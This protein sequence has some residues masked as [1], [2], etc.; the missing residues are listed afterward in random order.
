MKIYNAAIATLILLLGKTSAATTTK[1]H[2]SLREDQDSATR[3]N[4][5]DRINIRFDKITYVDGIP[6][7]GDNPRPM[8][9][10]DYPITLPTADFLRQT[11]AVSVIQQDDC[12][13]CDI[14]TRDLIRA[15]GGLPTH[16]PRTP[17]RSDPYWD[18]LYEV[19]EVQQG[20]L[21]DADPTLYMP[22]PKIWEDFDIH[23]VAEAVHDEVRNSAVD[24]KIWNT[25]RS[26]S[27]TYALLPFSV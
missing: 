2:T 20:R 19:I 8:T 22:L 14:P 25:P 21:D 4:L 17:N 26:D 27:L 7:P 5:Q 18:D 24:M 13:E 15:I 3:R 12:G 16:P 9:A 10:R 11:E 1:D 23:Q 6:P